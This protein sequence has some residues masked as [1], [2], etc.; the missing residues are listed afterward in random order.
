M[1]RRNKNRRKK[2]NN[3]GAPEI[4]APTIDHASSIAMRITNTPE[5]TL[6][7]DL[8]EHHH[9]FD[10]DDAHPLPSL[11]KFSAF[12]FKIAIDPESY[13]NAKRLSQVP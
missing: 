9:I 5:G 8:V 13:L 7:G 3:G 6:P 12:P 11:A 4:T 10:A 2:A 1:C